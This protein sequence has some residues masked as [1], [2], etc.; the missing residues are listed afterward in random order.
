M[1][2]TVISRLSPQGWPRVSSNRPWTQAMAVKKYQ[3]YSKCCRRYLECIECAETPILHCIKFIKMELKMP[4]LRWRRSGISSLFKQGIRT[5]AIAAHLQRGE[6]YLYP[7]GI[8][9]IAVQTLSHFCHLLA[10]PKNIPESHLSPASLVG[11]LSFRTELCI[12]KIDTLSPWCPEFSLG[13]SQETYGS[14]KVYLYSC[15][16]FDDPVILGA[17]N[18]VTY[19]SYQ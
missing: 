14:L 6:I 10:F 15:V 11:G 4:L 2:R 19:S 3:P 17:A 9:R 8:L 18:F 7:A 13:I 5:K 1:P 16:A 12:P